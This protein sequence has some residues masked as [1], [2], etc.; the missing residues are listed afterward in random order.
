MVANTPLCPECSCRPVR[1]ASGVCWKCFL[2]Q[3]DELDTDFADRP[4]SPW[5]TDALP[6]SAAKIAVLEERFRL[7]YALFSPKDARLTDGVVLDMPAHLC[8]RSAPNGQPPGRFAGRA[9]R[10]HFEVA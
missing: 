1:L 3:G 6:G 4:P 10:I 2:D 5:P 7:G 9:L 8:K